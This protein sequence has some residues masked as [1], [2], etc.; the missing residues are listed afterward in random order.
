MDTTPWLEL[1]RAAVA[2]VKAV[3]AAMPTREERE[4]PIGQG[5]GGDITAALDEAAENA[6]LKYFDRPDIRIVS[7]EIGI[8]G[9]GAI[10][11]LVDPIDG[12]Q[13]A[14]RAIPYFAL[15]VAVADGQTMDDVFFGFVYDF[16]ANEE[17]T[18]I[19]G[20]GAFLNDVPL[21]GRPKDFVEFL[22]IEATRAAVVLDRLEKLA[23]LTDRIRVMGAQAITFCHLAAGRT[24]AVVCLRASRT[25]DFAASQLLIRERGFSIIAVDGPE[26]GTL[27]LDLEARSR[28][29][30]AGTEELAL[31]IA[32]ALR[33]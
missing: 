22:S 11:V 10:T 15:C 9:E 29:C 25:V 20:G 8:K 1:C 19:R 33:S 32:A 14:E 6:V 4:R 13:N 21:T 30:A 26:L 7:E 18:A 2:D 28:I 3:L 16:G 5:K 31:G 27:P 24:D 23:P 17:W 12:S